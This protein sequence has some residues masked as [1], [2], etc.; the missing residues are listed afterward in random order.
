MQFTL[1]NIELRNKRSAKGTALTNSGLEG[2][3][4]IMDNGHILP[5]LLTNTLTIDALTFRWGPLR[6]PWLLPHLKLCLR[7]FLIFS[8]FIVGYHIMVQVAE[9]N[10]Y[11]ENFWQNVYFELFTR[12]GSTSLFCFSLI[13]TANASL[14]T[15][16]QSRTK[17]S[18]MQVTNRLQTGY[19]LEARE[20]MSQPSQLFTLQV[21]L[22]SL[23]ELAFHMEAPKF[24]V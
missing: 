14:I 6:P 19:C 7:T 20:V 18:P 1:S 13:S 12:Q 3:F 9:G 24:L 8:I 16:I 21:S 17:E 5:S 2:H 4:R 11:D 23:I 22:S 10:I 15:Y